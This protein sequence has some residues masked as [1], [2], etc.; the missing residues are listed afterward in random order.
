MYL[1]HNASK[2]QPMN[3]DNTPVR[4]GNLVMAD[5]APQ[6]K[7]AKARA[8]N[9][10]RIGYANV[11]LAPALMLLMVFAWAC[12]SD[13]TSEDATADEPTPEV[14][15]AA[16]EFVD[17]DANNF[18]RSTVIDNEWTPM[19][20][21]TKWVYDGFTIENNE[22]IPHRVEFTVTDLTKEIQ[23]VRTVVAS[24]VDISNGEVVEREIAF[25]AQDNDGTVWYFGEHPEEYKAGVFDNAPTWIAG[26]EEA[27]PGVKMWADPRVG[28]PSYFQGWAPTVDWSDY[29]TVDRAGEK[30]CVP[31]GC[32]ED[33]LVIAESSL[34][35]VGIY[36]L[37]YYARGVGEIQT[38]WRGNSES[39]EELQLVESDQLS[40]EALAAVRAEALALEAHAYKISGEYFYTT[41]S[42]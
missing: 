28:M 26:I 18:E 17:F 16:P 38:G 10:R 4:K 36:Q 1:K 42:E 14:T 5:M 19:V 39:P 31:S 25:Y 24:I 21:G 32:Y 33:V 12:G 29:G 40:P 20:P 2:N 8:S 23:G 11:L 15:A 34:D 6:K 27:K 3:I 30:V 37:K 9:R 41:P 35:E 7:T 22:K 13:P